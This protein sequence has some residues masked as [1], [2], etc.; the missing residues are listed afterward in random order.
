MEDDNKDAEG[1]KDNRFASPVH[2]SVVLEPVDHHDEDGH[3]GPLGDS[4]ILERLDHHDKD[5]TSQPASLDSEL[6]LLERRARKEAKREA[7]GE[8]KAVYDDEHVSA[9]RG[10]IVP[11]RID[12]QM[13]TKTQPVRLLHRLVSTA[14]REKRREGGEGETKGGK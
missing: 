11:E 1:D 3:V 10:S 14:A 12:H 5:A 8:G 7:K 9:I 6:P 2:H 13:R 4:T